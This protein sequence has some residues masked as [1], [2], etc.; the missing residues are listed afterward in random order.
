MMIRSLCKQRGKGKYLSH[1]T[2]KKNSLFS[3]KRSAGIMGTVTGESQMPAKEKLLRKYVDVWRHLSC[4][5]DTTVK[6]LQ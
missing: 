4:A 2:L 5:I 6:K 3:E 1:A